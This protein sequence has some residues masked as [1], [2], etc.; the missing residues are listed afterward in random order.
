MAE[1]RKPNGASAGARRAP[2]RRSVSPIRKDER[3][4]ARRREPLPAEP[5]APSWQLAKPKAKPIPARCAHG[6]S[7]WLMC[8]ECNPSR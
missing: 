6:W 3:S 7:S 1:T 5:S 8:P 2:V 4:S